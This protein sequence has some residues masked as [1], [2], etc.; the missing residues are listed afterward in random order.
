MQDLSAYFICFTIVLLPDSPAP[1][2]QSHNTKVTSMQLRRKNT[3]DK[4]AENRRQLDKLLDLLCRATKYITH[5]NA[6][7][8]LLGTH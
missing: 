4:G 7:R 6:V 1:A 2:I 5:V 8:R 3:R